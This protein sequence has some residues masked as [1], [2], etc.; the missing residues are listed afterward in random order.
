MRRLA[1]LAAVALLLASG[2]QASTRQQSGFVTIR[3]GDEIRL[4]GSLTGCVVQEL[5]VI[6]LHQ[7][8]PSPPGLIAAQTGS[9]GTLLVSFRQGV[10]L[11]RKSTGTATTT[12]FA[13]EPKGLP[14]L[15]AVPL[16]PEQADR[17][18]NLKVGQVARVQGTRLDCAVVRTGA[19]PGVPTVYCSNDDA[20][21]PIPGSYA[22]LVSDRD[23]A[24]GLVQANRSTKIVALRRQP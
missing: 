11:F 1:G 21:G 16:A 2:A 5:A 18:L 15:G 3:A 23:A 12:L 4:A 8:R 14:D 10:Q 19:A 6:C 7:A 24:V 9:Y 13:W 22:T 17:V 20:R